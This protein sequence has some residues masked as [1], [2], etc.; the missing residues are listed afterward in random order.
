M[1]LCSALERLRVQQA[2]PDIHKRARNKQMGCN[3]KEKV[4]RPKGVLVDDYLHKKNTA[5][6]KS[7]RRKNY[8]HRRYIPVEVD[9]NIPR[10]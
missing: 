9:R 1:T 10:V 4:E 5:Q 2:H 6:T 7:C 8:Q 3:H